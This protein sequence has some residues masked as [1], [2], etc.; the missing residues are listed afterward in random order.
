MARQLLQLNP[1]A[2]VILDP[3]CGAGTVLIE[4]A[5]AGKAAT[6]SD[7]SPLAAFVARHHAD[8]GGVSLEELRAQA[9]AIV[10]GDQ[11]K[12]DWNDLRSRLRRLPEGSV[13]SALWFCLLVALQRAGDGEEAYA[14]AG[15]KSFVVSQSS[16][17]PPQQLAQPMFSG[18]VELYA[19]QLRALRASV[20]FPGLV[21]TSC[22]DVRS[23][24]LSQPAHAVVTSPPYPGVYNYAKAQIPGQH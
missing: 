20:P 24:Q 19:A 21:R 6:G 11:P 16:G 10:A 8:V 7:A 13:K 1:S 2:S 18:T 9:M 15:S 12:L 5:L 22:G 4:A 17:D 3:F 14:L 23:L